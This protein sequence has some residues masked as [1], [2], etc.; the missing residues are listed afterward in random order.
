MISDFQLLLMVAHFE[1]CKGLAYQRQQ[2][3]CHVVEDQVQFLLCTY[4]YSIKIIKKQAQFE[5]V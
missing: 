3:T 2:Q 1:V 5:P 4:L